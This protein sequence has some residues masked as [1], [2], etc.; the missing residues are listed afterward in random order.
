MKDLLAVILHC[1]LLTV[2]RGPGHGL[3]CFRKSSSLCDL[4]IV[5]VPRGLSEG[6][7]VSEPSSN[8][9]TDDGPLLV[10]ITSDTSFPVQFTCSCLPKDGVCCIAN[11]TSPGKLMHGK[12]VQRVTEGVQQVTVHCTVF[13]NQCPLMDKQPAA[14]MPFRTVLC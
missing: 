10:V 12:L 8:S 4:G 11:Q 1:G 13:P 6:N 14:L 9:L 3:R 7:C 2:V 5:T